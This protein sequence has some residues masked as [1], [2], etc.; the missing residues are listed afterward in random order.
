MIE[1]SEAIS[2]DD[3]AGHYDDLDEYYRLLWGDHLHHG[4][5][6]SGRESTQEAIEQMIEHCSS[7]LQVES[8]AVVCDV[9]C[10]YGGTSRY[11]AEEKGLR[12]T[13]LTI[14]PRQYE[15][16]IKRLEGADN[17]RFLLR[18]WEQNELDA[19]HFDGIISLECIA[20]VSNK[21]VFFDQVRRVLKPGARAVVTHWTSA[22]D[23]SVWS[24]RWLLEPICREGRLPGMGSD[25]DYRRLAENSSLVVEHHDDLAKKVRWTWVICLWRMLIMLL[26][27]PAGWR[28]VFSS[29]SR[30][31]VYAFSIFRI[32][33]AYY[34]GSMKYGLFVLR[35][36]TEDL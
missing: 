11:L 7:F 5:W 17:P 27:T 31:A 23:A 28:F 34:L 24:N 25:E 33:V 8:G 15:Y 26:F 2:L 4:L 1:S 21:Q 14:S 6:L 16:A 32:L 35:R 3:V 36:P 9:G 22:A 30:H 19:Q 29:K 12:M 20:H 18:D 10:G 13:G